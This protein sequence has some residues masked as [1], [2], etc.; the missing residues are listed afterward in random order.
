[1]F[2]GKNSVTV[3][4]NVKTAKK[5]ERKVIGNRPDATAAYDQVIN[6]IIVHKVFRISQLVDTGHASTLIICNTWKI[7][8][9]KKTKKTRVFK[10]DFQDERWKSIAVEKIKKEFP[11][12]PFFPI[13][14]SKPPRFGWRLAGAAIDE[15]IKQSGLAKLPECLESHGPMVDENGDVFYGDA[16][17]PKEM[18]PWKFVRMVKDKYLGRRRDND[19]MLKADEIAAGSL[20]L[21]RDLYKF[22]LDREIISALM[23]LDHRDISIHEYLQAAMMREHFMRLVHESKNMLPI[24]IKAK[25][26]IWK[27]KSFFSKDNWMADGKNTKK[28]L[29]A[30]NIQ[31]NMDTPVH[32]MNHAAYTPFRTKAAFRWFKAAPITVVKKWAQFNRSSFP[33]EVVAHAN[34]RGKIPAIAQSALLQQIVSLLED[35]RAYW[36]YADDEISL[37]RLTPERLQRL[38]R[39]YA[40]NISDHWKEHGFLSVKRYLK[41][42]SSKI[43]YLYDWLSAEG[44][45]AG[46]PSKHDTWQSMQRDCDTWHERILEENRRKLAEKH[47]QLAAMRWVSLI[48][49]VEIDGITFT[50]LTSALDLVKE[51]DEMM[52]CVG[53][54]GYA[55]VCNAGHYRIFSS[56]K[57]D[58]MRGT[59][60]LQ[61]V[62]NKT[63]QPSIEIQQYKAPYN[64]PVSRD[65]SVAAEKLAALY[66]EKLIDAT[67]KKKAG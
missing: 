23:A 52:H 29:L 44:F 10:F 65:E 67:Q 62:Y 58:G 53:G 2:D 34:I 13:N 37:Q 63:G 51:G 47:A 19:G 55:K 7:E 57:K 28:F 27:D 60:C 24:V 21:R 32:A 59:L 3:L 8:V 16:S 30:K 40:A 42:N 12:F 46:R 20:A 9:K 49:Q 11:W 4:Q 33:I 38:A 66:E 43:G 14:A 41:E 54:Y 36:D 35:E 25:P 31:G 17:S 45:A 61:I 56:I 22:I 5:K 1:M 18:P 6:W 48:G 39:C 50:P 15:L 26:T 64:D